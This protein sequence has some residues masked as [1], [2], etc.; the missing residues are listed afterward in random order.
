MHIKW[1][2]IQCCIII[3]A[4]QKDDAIHGQ[5]KA[6][7]KKTCGDLFKEKA[8]KEG[9][10]ESE[11]TQA[12]DE[13]EFEDESGDK[14]D[15]KFCCCTGGELCNEVLWPSKRGSELGDFVPGGGSQRSAQT[16]RIF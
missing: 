12:C 2:V 3:L 15:G 6:M 7:S 14:L 1:D 13:G 11:V 8:E 5:V 4:A 10:D 9:I 16:G